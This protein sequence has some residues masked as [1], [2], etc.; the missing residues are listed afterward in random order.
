M[1]SGW[2]PED[3]ENLPEGWTWARSC[4]ECHG[5]M[6]IVDVRYGDIFC[7]DT[8]EAEYDSVYDREDDDE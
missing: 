6:S 2:R 8:C 5:A 7:C 3:E 1:N 4:Q